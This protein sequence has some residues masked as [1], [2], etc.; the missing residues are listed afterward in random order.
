MVSAGINTFT[1]DGKPAS[2][3][4]WLYAIAHYKV[5]EY[6]ADPYNRFMLRPPPID[7]HPPTRRPDHS[8]ASAGGVHPPDLHRLLE[9]IR[10]DWNAFWKCAV[11]ERSATDVAKELGMSPCAVETAVSTVQKCLREEDDDGVPGRVLLL[12]GLL[13]LI[14][15]DF[16]RTTFRAFE[17]VAVDGRS[18]EEA[19]KEE[20]LNTVGAVYTAK[21]KVLKRLREEFEALGF[22]SSDADVVKDDVAIV[23]NHEVT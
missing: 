4:R 5:L 14:R 3:R 12:R 7:F 13:E 22:G 18:S 23:A 11:E 8:G 1:K 21:C 10:R 15:N 20:D 9:S 6:W 16:E 17:R 2:F 19:R